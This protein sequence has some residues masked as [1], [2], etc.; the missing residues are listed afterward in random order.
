MHQEA[1]DELAC[2]ERHH[3]VVSLGAIKA[4]ILPLEGDALVVGRDQAAVG[5]GDV[6]GQLLSEMRLTTPRSSRQD[7]QTLLTISP[8]VEPYR[9]A[10]RPPPRAIAQRFS[11]LAPLRHGGSVSRCPLTGVD[12]KKRAPL[13]TT[14]LT[15]LR[16][17]RCPPVALLSTKGDHRPRTSISLASASPCHHCA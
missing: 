2:I 6:V 11:A 8:W 7:D 3:P 14:R 5:D 4:I 17:L 9:C 10:P 1:A 15:H 13:Q 12:W 16:N